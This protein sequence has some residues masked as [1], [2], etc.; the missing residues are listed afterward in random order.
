MGKTRDE[1]EAEAAAKKAS[2]GQPGDVTPPG[3][4]IEDMTSDDGPLTAGDDPNDTD[5]PEPGEVDGENRMTAEDQLV[6]NEERVRSE[7]IT[8]ADDIILGANYVFVETGHT[9]LA[10]MTSKHITGCDRVT[11]RVIPDAGLLGEQKPQHI[12]VDVTM[13]LYVDEGISERVEKINALQTSS[14]GSPAAARPGAL[15]TFL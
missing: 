4:P 8:S 14:E 7:I 9:G 1:I 5:V 2:D 11:I 15:A 10:V 3:D 13:V 6:H 12:D